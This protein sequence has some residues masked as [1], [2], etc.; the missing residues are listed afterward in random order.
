MRYKLTTG[1]NRFFPAHSS[2]FGSTPCDFPSSL[3]SLGVKIS[4][5][6]SLSVSDARECWLQ[7]PEHIPQFLDDC[8]RLYSFG[9]ALNIIWINWFVYIVYTSNISPN[10]IFLEYDIIWIT[11]APAGAIPFL[12]LFSWAPHK[13]IASTTPTIVNKRRIVAPY[14]TL[15]SILLTRKKPWMIFDWVAAIF[16]NFSRCNVI[17]IHPFKKYLAR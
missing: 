16:I 10:T 12:V 11:F 3:H 9:L 17:L 4:N 6:A 8:G 13:V 5:W 1:K 14:V 2:R 7:C 15:A